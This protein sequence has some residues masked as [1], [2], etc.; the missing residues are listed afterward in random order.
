M[1]YSGEKMELMDAILKEFSDNT[2]LTSK[3]NM[4][5]QVCVYFSVKEL[6]IAPLFLI[7]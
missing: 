3:E 7:L 2:S 4:I 5:L 6:V 1:A